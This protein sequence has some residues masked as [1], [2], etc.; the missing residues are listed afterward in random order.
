MEKK[1]SFL[2]KFCIHLGRQYAMND[3]YTRVYFMDCLMCNHQLSTQSPLSTPPHS[4]P[5]II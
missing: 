3:I 2:S 5:L 4:Y 1:V